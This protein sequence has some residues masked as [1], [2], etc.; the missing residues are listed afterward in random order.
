MLTFSGFQRQVRSSDG[1][2]GAEFT[3][4]VDRCFRDIIALSVTIRPK[5]FSEINNNETM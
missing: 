5:H 4:L 1:E 2:V 3:L